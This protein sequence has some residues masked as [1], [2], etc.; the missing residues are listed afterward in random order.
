MA[1]TRTTPSLDLAA[2][3]AVVAA[4]VTGWTLSRG[5]P[6]PVPFDGGLRVDVGLPVQRARY[7]LPRFEPKRL[8][9]LAA[10]LSLPWTFLKVCAPPD[11]VAQALPEGWA[12]QAPV[13]MMTA[14][15][16]RRDGSTEPPRG[17]AVH[18]SHDGAVI[19]ATLRDSLGELAASGCM[20]LTESHAVFDRI[21]TD[22]AHR[23]RGLGSVVMTVLSQEAAARGVDAAVLVATQD[24]HGLYSALGWDLHSPVTSCVVPGDVA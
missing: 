22:A 16:T 4:W 21:E 3:P 8:H 23:R 12:V 19:S 20:A 7:V 24:G 14:S 9:G 2:D 15:L 18:L 1:L 11:I 5:T 10:S 6:P 13:F 17:Y